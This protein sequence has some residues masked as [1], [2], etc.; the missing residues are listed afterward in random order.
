M[1][2][3]A[4]RSS[5]TRLGVG[6]F[7]VAEADNGVASSSAE[8]ARPAAASNGFLRKSVSP[9]MG[10]GLATEPSN[11]SC[12]IQPTPEISLDRPVNCVN[13][14]R[15][16]AACRTRECALSLSKRA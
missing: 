16:I 3:G 4:A 2:N 1:L 12:P 11:M 15:Q 8:Q 5:E 13:R 14:F 7:G 10:P 6:T 9:E